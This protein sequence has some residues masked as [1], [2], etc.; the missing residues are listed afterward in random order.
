M[1]FGEIFYKWL[2]IVEDEKVFA[3]MCAHKTKK[4]YINTLRLMIGKKKDR[5]HFKQRYKE[6]VEE[7]K[8]IMGVI[9]KH[10]PMLGMFGG[11]YSY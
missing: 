8:K 10:F 11:P 1:S 4:Q 5:G 3:D 6:R 7:Q 9:T 2:N